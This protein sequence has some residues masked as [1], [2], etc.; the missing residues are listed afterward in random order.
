ML[1]VGVFIVILASLGMARSNQM[2]EENQLDE[3]LLI[4]EKRMGNLTVTELQAEL[5]KLQAKLDKREAQISGAKTSLHQDI[6]SVDVTDKFFVI[7]EESNVKVIAL[8]TTVIVEMPLEDIICSMIS[9][10]A[11]LQGD[12]PDLV[13]F[14]TNVNEGYVSGYIDTAQI[15]IPEIEKDEEPLA[16][17]Q[18]AVYSYEGN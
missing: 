13:G 10:S 5:E 16:N 6:E 15:I 7:A 3:Q 18:M 14:I 4:S 8:S 1:A 17:I 12:V 11:T 9:L 2:Q